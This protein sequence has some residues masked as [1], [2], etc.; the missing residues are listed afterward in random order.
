MYCNHDVNHD[1]Q[2]SALIC[3]LLLRLKTNIT[4]DRHHESEKEPKANVKKGNK[5]QL[6]KQKI[7]PEVGNFCFAHVRGYS[8]WP[9]IIT[10][11]KK[12][13]HVW[14]KFFNSTEM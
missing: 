7:M 13:N 9:A 4:V 10:A 8:E 2:E 5:L 11:I 1:F 14:V 6:A 3:L 12:P